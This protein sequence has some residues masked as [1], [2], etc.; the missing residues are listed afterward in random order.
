MHTNKYNT[1]KNM[2]K[3]IIPEKKKLNLSKNY[4]KY[5]NI[6]LNVNSK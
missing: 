4:F 6:I 3:L 5:K 1:Y 2:N